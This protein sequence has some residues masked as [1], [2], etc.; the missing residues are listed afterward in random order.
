M[1]GSDLARELLGRGHCK[2]GAAARKMIERADVRSTK[3]VGFKD[4]Y[5]YYLS[6]HYPRR[7]VQA[8]LHHLPTRPGLWRVVSRLLAN[9]G[10]ITIG[11]IAK[12]S[13]ILVDGHGSVAR[14][15]GDLQSVIDALQTLQLVEVASEDGRLFRN[16][17]TLGIPK[18][19]REEFLADL[20]WEQGLLALLV[21]GLRKSNVIA[22][23]SLTTRWTPQSYVPWFGAAWDAEGVCY[24]GPFATP[25]DAPGPAKAYLLIDIVGTRQC[26][27]D[28][29]RSLIARFDGLLMRR[30]SKSKHTA[31]FPVV[32][33]PAYSPKALRLL[34]RRGIVTLRLEHVL[35][36]DAADLLRRF[37]RIARKARKTPKVDPKELAKLLRQVN[38]FK[39]LKG[40]LWRIR[41]ELF[42]TLVALAWSMRGY[43]TRREFPLYEPEADRMLPVDVV[44]WTPAERVLIEC[45]GRYPDSSDKESD[46]ERFFDDKCRLAAEKWKKRPSALRAIYV[47]TGQLNRDMASTHAARGDEHGFA[48]EVWGRAEL[49]E[50]LRS[51]KAKRLVYAVNQYFKRFSSKPHRRGTRSREEASLSSNPVRGGA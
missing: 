12:A 43:K 10:W 46:L 37:R 16:H 49:V 6:Q 32:L 38:E 7:Y 13:G 3:P 5:L 39:S 27:R 28:D 50:F 42:A 25:G 45:K 15:T 8:V 41:G 19:P 33:A 2:S 21:S 11:G 4:A 1:L 17:R 9:R 29:A 24:L 35:G 47:S 44:A 40:F 30:S 51:V 48:S 18:A 22:W 36:P 34:Q 14:P 31:F 20:A 23:R 26:R